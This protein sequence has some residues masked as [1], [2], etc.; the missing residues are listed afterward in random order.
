MR[1]L[2]AVTV[3]IT[4][5][6]V[7]ANPVVA[8]VRPCCCTKRVEPERACCQQVAERV[9]VQRACCAKKTETAEIARLSNGCCCVKAPPA[10]TPSRDNLATSEIKEQ[11]A[12]VTEFVPSDLAVRVP[13]SIA[14]DRAG[15]RISLSGPP[16]LALYCIWLK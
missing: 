11:S 16:L 1:T 14:L 13:A 6:A 10:S 9:S 3:A 5:I 2:K 4:L 12:G 15:D 8:M 7:T